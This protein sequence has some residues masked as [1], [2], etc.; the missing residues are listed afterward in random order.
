MTKMALCLCVVFTF[1][2]EAQADVF[3]SGPHAFSIKFVTVGN[4]G[5]AADTTGEPRP[6]GAVPYAY[7]IAKYEISEGI[8]DSVNALSGLNITHDDRGPGRPA[9]NISWYEATQFVNWLNTNQGFAPAYK[10]VNDNFEVWGPGDLGY[11]PTNLFRNGRAMYFLPSADEWYKAAYYDPTTSAYYDYPTGSDSPPDGIDFAG[12][13]LFDAVIWD[14][15]TSVSVH[16]VD[17]VGAPSPYGTYGQGGN[18]HEWEET[19]RDLVNDLSSPF[20]AYRGGFYAGSAALTRSSYRDAT[21]RYLD[22]NNIG[23][24]V[25]SRIPE[26]NTLLLGVLAGLGL[27]L[28]RK[29]LRR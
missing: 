16:D 8:I 24:R 13:P 26:P 4:A 1:T 12:D 10:F 18:V 28:S 5:N 14:G 3:G 17:N 22:F 23:I 21:F 15:V 29:R 19:E 25:A 7:R 9:S 2:V 11:D 20:Q 6:A 27:L